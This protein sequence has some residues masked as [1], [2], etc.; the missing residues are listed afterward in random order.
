MGIG[1]LD[2]FQRMRNG[3]FKEYKIFSKQ[4]EPVRPTFKS[5][6]KVGGR[7]S[8]HLKTSS[9]PILVEEINNI[10]RIIP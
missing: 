1:E 5:R 7:S 10:E 9:D 8:I 3:Y 4:G 2:E 6:G